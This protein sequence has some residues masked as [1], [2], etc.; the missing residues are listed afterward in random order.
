MLIQCSECG[1]Q[2]SDK[3]AFCPNCG[4]PVSK[5]DCENYCFINDIKYDL[6][7]IMEIL[8]KVGDK[9]T[10]VHPLIIKAMIREKTPLDI[11]TSQELADIIL[12]TKKIPDEFNGKIDTFKISQT[13]IN[14]PKCPTCGSTNIEKIGGLERGVS[15]AMWGLFSKKINKSFKCKSCGYT[16]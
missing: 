4:C 9:D 12:A 2:I 6:T 3:A 11:Q 8:P 13:Q 10:D 7:D 1:K 15:V 16:W 14:T 5:M